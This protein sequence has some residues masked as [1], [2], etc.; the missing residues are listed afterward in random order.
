[1]FF[2]SISAY[3]KNFIGSMAQSG[4]TL[5]EVRTSKMLRDSRE[6]RTMENGNDL[7]GAEAQKVCI[8]L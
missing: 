8:D 3:N 2:C 6:N 5:C 4:T 1:M 7:T